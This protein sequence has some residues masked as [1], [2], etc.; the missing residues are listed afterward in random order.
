M[1]TDWSRCSGRDSEMGTN[2]WQNI[3]R[4]REDFPCLHP[5]D[6]GRIFRSKGEWKIPEGGSY[7]WWIQ[8]LPF[9]I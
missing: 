9:I 8:G 1:V 6:V 2:K 4:P 7:D 5:D 3:P